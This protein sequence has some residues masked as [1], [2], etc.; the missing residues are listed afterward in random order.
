MFFEHCLTLLDKI[1]MINRKRFI[2]KSAFVKYNQSGHMVKIT[3]IFRYI[4]LKVRS[5]HTRKYII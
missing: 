4:R 3:N 1:T 2:E 5:M